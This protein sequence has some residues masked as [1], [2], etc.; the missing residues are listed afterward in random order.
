MKRKKKRAISESKTELFSPFSFESL[1]RP[2]VKMAAELM[3]IRTSVIYEW[4]EQAQIN[5]YPDD[6]LSPEAVDLLV[7]KYLEKTKRYFQNCI[8]TVSEMD[9]DDFHLFSE[10]I[11]KYRKPFRSAKKW[12]DIN[13]YRIEKDFRNEL[14]SKALDDYFHIS[15]AIVISEYSVVKE[16]DIFG[17]EIYPSRPVNTPSVLFRITRSYQYNTV[18]R[19]KIPKKPLRRN[20]LREILLENR[21]HIFVDESDHN[22]QFEASFTYL[23]LNQPQVAIGDCGTQRLQ[24]IEFN[25][26]KK[27]SPTHC[28]CAA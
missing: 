22:G 6:K 4:L 24:H 14:Q 7:A 20:I 27:T 1:F 11:S 2:T 10:F 8:E 25:E 13:V 28:C 5:I 19:S 12:D 23:K 9:A 16:V 18:S 17:H 21:F 3:N 26:D 15:D